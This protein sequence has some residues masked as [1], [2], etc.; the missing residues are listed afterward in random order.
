MK[1]EKKN[2][3]IPILLAL[4]VMALWGSLYPSVKLSYQWFDVDTSYYPNL[5]L[6]AGIRFTIAS[7]TSSTP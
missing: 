1:E 7:N 2:S 4:I 3:L 6:Y 5:L